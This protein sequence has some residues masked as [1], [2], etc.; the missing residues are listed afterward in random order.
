MITKGEL[1]TTIKEDNVFIDYLQTLCDDWERYYTECV[2]LNKEKDAT[3]EG[4]YKTIDMLEENLDKNIEDSEQHIKKLEE[5]VKQLLN[6][7]DEQDCLS[8][9]KNDDGEWE[10]DWDYCY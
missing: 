2:D 7:M 4:L 1:R 8:I 10:C 5:E 9:S 6:L 3:I